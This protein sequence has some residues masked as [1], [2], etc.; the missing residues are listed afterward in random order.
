M[1]DRI[2]VKLFATLQKRF[3]VPDS[4]SFDSPQT[5]GEIIAALQIPPEKVSV[6]FINNRHA[7]QTD[8]VSP[9]DTLSLF[10]PV[11]GG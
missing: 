10:P 6:V 7:D 3:A 11:G 5:V 8:T 4:L 9:G 2:R 1:S